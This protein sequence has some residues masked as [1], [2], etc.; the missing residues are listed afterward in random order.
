MYAP[1]L[2]GQR[3]SAVGADSVT[4]D[5]QQK[6]PGFA[7]RVHEGLHDIFGDKGR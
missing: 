6:Y 4:A 2:S 7:D 3:M 1:D 5:L